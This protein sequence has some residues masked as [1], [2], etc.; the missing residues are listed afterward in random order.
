VTVPATTIWPGSLTAP[1]A[2]TFALNLTVPRLFRLAAVMSP[3]PR[4]APLD[5]TSCE[6][7]GGQV[8][9]LASIEPRGPP[10]GALDPG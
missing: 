2:A 6:N 1:P 10:E 4:L 5:L 3:P 9:V 8:R 7:G